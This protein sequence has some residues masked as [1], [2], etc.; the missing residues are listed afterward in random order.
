MKA[1][2]K[3]ATKD[4]D[5][6]FFAKNYLADPANKGKD[7]SD[8]KAAYDNKKPTRN[9][10]WADFYKDWKADPVNDG[11]TVAEARMDFKA[12]KPT[13]TSEKNATRAS[14]TAAEI[15]KMTKQVGESDKAFQ[16][17][18]DKRYRELMT[19]IPSEISDQILLAQAKRTVGAKKVGESEE[20]Y[21]KRISD[22]YIRL[23]RNAAKDP[24]P[25]KDP[26][27]VAMDKS[28]QAKRK[29]VVTD[30]DQARLNAN[31]TKYEPITQLSDIT[32]EEWA[33]MDEQEFNDL[34]MAFNNTK[35][36]LSEAQQ[37]EYSNMTNSMNSLDTISKTY[38]SDQSG[39]GQNI[40][41]ELG[42]FTGIDTSTDKI[43]DRAVLNKAIASLVIEEA[44]AVGGRPSATLINMMKEEVGKL[45]DSDPAVY[46]KFEQSIKT[47]IAKLE[48]QKK[49]NPDG[50][51][52][53]YKGDPLAKMKNVKRNLEIANGKGKGGTV[54]TTEEAKS[55]VAELWKD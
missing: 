36:K 55:V 30:L 44:T 29:Q 27:K 9:T 7:I 12:H 25:A 46:A 15:A 50:Y 8:A 6:K 21:Q 23:D 43:K 35:S 45:K 34:K 40:L 5:F 33:S 26:D 16:D 10:E 49:N 53:R 2:S 54:P 22:E 28:Y 18:K 20:S 1:N 31:P 38:N 11:K 51:Y 3:L 24:T 14:T 47:T 13:S 39:F 17:R 4:S 19:N 41:R 52:L 48:A 37:K 42:V 32:A